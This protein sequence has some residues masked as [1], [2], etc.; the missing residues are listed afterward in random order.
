VI[1]NGRG[2]VPSNG[3]TRHFGLIGMRERVDRLHGSL[4]LQSDEGKGTHV[5]FSFPLDPLNLEFSMS[6]SGKEMRR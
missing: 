1:D 2:F 6:E 3:D 5:N 4:S